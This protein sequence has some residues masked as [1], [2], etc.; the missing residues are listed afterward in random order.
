MH[1]KHQTLILTSTCIYAAASYTLHIHAIA[2][3]LPI[4][5]YTCMLC[6]RT[7]ICTA[8]EELREYQREVDYMQRMMSSLDESA[9]DF[10]V[11]LQEFFKVSAVVFS[12]S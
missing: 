1:K 2:P 11:Q 9:E 6:F 12:L 10:S 3:I 4:V 8:E 7:S 5:L